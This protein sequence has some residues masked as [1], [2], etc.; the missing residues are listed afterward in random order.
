MSETRHRAVQPAFGAVI[1]FAMKIMFKNG[2]CDMQY[3][4]KWSI[5]LFSKVTVCIA[6]G[7]A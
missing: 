4:R 6:V 1:M 5:S 7:R 2:I 3:Y